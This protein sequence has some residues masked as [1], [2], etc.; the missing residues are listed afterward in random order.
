MSSLPREIIAFLE[1]E[2]GQTL[3]V[4]GRSGTGKTTF[5]FSLLAELARS[6]P[7]QFKPKNFLY[8]SSRVPISNI[9]DQFPWAFQL[10]PPESFIDA[11]RSDLEAG[12]GAPSQEQ[13][14]SGQPP[15][16]L[17][18]PSAFYSDELTF[19]SA[20]NDRLRPLERGVC[21]IDSFDGFV[22]STRADPQ[23]LAVA[24]AN[25]SRSCSA[26]IILVLEGEQD[27]PLDHIVDGIVCLTKS[28]VDGQ[29]WRE[30]RMDKLRGTRVDQ[31]RRGFSLVGARFQVLQ[32]YDVEKG[33][34]ISAF[35]VVQHSGGRFSSGIP[36]LDEILGG[37]RRGSTIFL[38]VGERVHNEVVNTLILNIVAN[39]I[40]QGGGV[41]IVPPNKMSH[42]RLKAAALRYGFVDQL[43]TRL[44]FFASAVSGLT[45][46]GTA[47]EL[48]EPYFKTIASR[49]SKELKT[50]WDVAVEELRRQ[51]CSTILGVIG[52]GWLQSWLGA[53]D[54][55]RWA[56]RLA[57]DTATESNLAVAVGY[58]STPDVN[59]FIADLSDTHVILTTKAGATLLRGVNPP[60][61]QYC[62]YTRTTEKG[63]QIAFQE[64]A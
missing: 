11:T 48:G 32:T 45:V 23:R 12:P 43:N 61:P 33:R 42:R 4:K 64:I 35:K 14:P 55:P 7:D 63:T 54:L 37:F 1:R 15:S 3:M 28:E 13:A 22:E 53:T 41:V 29:V 2:Q 44:R 60:T 26:K 34:R 5:A 62:I 50:A 40:L 20:I 25:L 49:E 17:T 31:F 19:I 27:S 57:S 21:I 6:L 24:L 39:F 59:R 10:L 52:F 58:S 8:I 56:T 9:Q 30:I 36:E 16:E 38:E 18:S 46:S 51:G 47:A